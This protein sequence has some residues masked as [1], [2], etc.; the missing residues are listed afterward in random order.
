MSLFTSSLRVVT[1]L[2]ALSVPLDAVPIFLEG[3][4]ADPMLK[5]GFPTDCG[6][7]HVNPNGGGERN[8]FGRFFESQLDKITPLLRARDGV[9]FV[10]PIIKISDS[11]TIHFSDP[12]KKQSVIEMPER[13][14]VVIDVKSGKA[15]INP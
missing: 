12:E 8:R 3:L 1:I 2:L 5:P 14:F 4:Q 13:K 7:C 6:T 9:K 11:I 15:V 10:Y